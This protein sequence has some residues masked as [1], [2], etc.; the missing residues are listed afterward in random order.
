M[1]SAVASGPANDE[2]Q[3]KRILVRR[4][5]VEMLTIP[6]RVFLDEVQNPD[7]NLA[8]K[9]GDLRVSD[10]LAA[11]PPLVWHGFHRPS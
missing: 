8:W 10:E 4:K 9:G 5:T 3:N 2:V 1:R 6:R 7:Q 11:R